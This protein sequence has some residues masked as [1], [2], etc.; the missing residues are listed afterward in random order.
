M[1]SWVFSSSAEATWIFVVRSSL[2]GVGYAGLVLLILSMLPDV[3]EH[4]FNR[5][6][7]RREGTI[8]AVFAFVEKLAYAITPLATGVLLK[9]TGYVQG[10]GGVLS[11][12]PGAILGIKL[13]ISLM[14]AGLALLGLVFL[15]F[16]R[17]DARL[18]RAE[19][20]QV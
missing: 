1:F 12:P 18:L 20:R 8:S 9:L 14:P 2:V 11:Q 13:G 10:Q 17:L 16:Y 4:D 3:I 19:A 5:T 7:L 15:W 6:G